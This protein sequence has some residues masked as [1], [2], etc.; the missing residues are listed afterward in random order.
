MVKSRYIGDGHP[1]FNRNPYNGPTIGLMSL[2][3]IIWNYWEFRPQ[4]KWIPFNF[5]LPPIFTEPWPWLKLLRNSCLPLE[6]I[7]VWWFLWGMKRK[8]R[9]VGGVP[10]G[11]C[12]FTFVCMYIY[13]Y[14]YNVYICYIYK[15]YIY[16]YQHLPVWVPIHHQPVNSYHL[17]LFEK[18]SRSFLVFC[19]LRGFLRSFCASLSDTGPSN[20]SPV[21]SQPSQKRFLPG[22]LSSPP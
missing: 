1:T 13:I 16:I 21:N 10:S 8:L 6:E 15:Y 2:S 9:C 22:S 17:T 18:K 12:F 11:Q 14:V 3:P 19:Y 4:H 7:D 5:Y 20:T